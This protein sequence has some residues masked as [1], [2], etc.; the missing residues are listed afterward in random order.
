[1]PGASSK[2]NLRRS[3]IYRNLDPEEW[4]ARNEVPEEEI[5]IEEY[6]E[7]HGDYPFIPDYPGQKTIR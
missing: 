7:M 3:S 5:D 2:T 6:C 1:M 4:E